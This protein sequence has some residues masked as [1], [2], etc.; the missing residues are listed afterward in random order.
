MTTK[1]RQKA[2]KSVK[3]ALHKMHGGALRS[4]RSG[5]KVTNPEQAIAIG[6]SDARAKGGE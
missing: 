1:N 3:T 6:L 5:K 2:S 4:G